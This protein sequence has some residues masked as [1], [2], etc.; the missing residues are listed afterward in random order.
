MSAN[1]GKISNSFEDK[2]L[3]S[4]IGARIQLLKSEKKMNNGELAAA[5]GVSRQAVSLMLGRLKKGE[6]VEIPTL[7]RVAKVLGVK[8]KDFF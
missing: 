2:I 8:V 4:E 6:G 3:F 7:N 1:R 5:L